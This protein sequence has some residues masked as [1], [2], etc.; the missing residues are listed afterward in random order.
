M[1]K[2]QIATFYICP[3]EKRYGCNAAIASLAMMLVSVAG[4]YA[5]QLTWFGVLCLALF[6]VTP[7]GAVAGGAPLR[8]VQDT[9]SQSVPSG[10]LC[11]AGC[12]SP[13]PGDAGAVIWQGRSSGVEV[14]WTKGDIT[15]M[16][17]DAQM[18][19]IYSARHE[20]LESYK[21]WAADMKAARD[22]DQP[23]KRSSEAV[24]D[25]KCVWSKQ[26]RILSLVGTLLSLEERD[27]THCDQE[28]H[29]GGETRFLTLDL[30]ASSLGGGPPGADR[31]KQLADFFAEK[32]IIR[33]LLKD[34]LIQRALGSNKKTK[35]AN[36]SELQQALT[37]PVLD[38]KYCYVAGPDILRGFAF[39]H[40]ENGKVA[41]RIGLPGTGACR[42]NLTQIGLLLPVP[43]S[44]KAAF[45]K[46]DSRAE[47]FLMQDSARISGSSKTVLEFPG[48][49][50]SDAPSKP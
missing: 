6:A 16:R 21:V 48:D 44:M 20:A 46:A 1:V 18:V 12:V 30:A 15:A 29:P 37:N 41:V 42:Q 39:H 31:P 2:Q 27:Y 5:R 32:D 35:Y 34:A 4:L 26:V 23:V 9:S 24:A 8:R 28:A 45:E 25:P 14:R 47:G 50:T 22:P 17:T 33:A 36:L 38:E 10:A 43:P 13:V 49:T 11:G 19:L 3:R 40:V 7:V